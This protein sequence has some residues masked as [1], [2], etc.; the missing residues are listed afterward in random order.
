MTYKLVNLQIGLNP[1]VYFGGGGIY[2]VKDSCTRNMR[3]YLL[4]RRVYEIIILG[5]PHMNNQIQ[6]VNY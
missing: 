1:V 3:Y 6:C 2:V 5:S 4:R